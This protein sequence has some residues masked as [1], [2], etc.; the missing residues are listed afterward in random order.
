MP[1]CNACQR[2]LPR[3]HVEHTYEQGDCKWAEAP[4]RRSGPRSSKRP[5]E[6]VPKA[7]AEPTAGIPAN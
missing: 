5:R 1:N 4:Y 6:P 7:H 3:H 2:R